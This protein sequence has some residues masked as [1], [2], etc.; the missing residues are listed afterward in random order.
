MTNKNKILILDQLKNDEIYRIKFSR[1]DLIGKLRYRSAKYCITPK[2]RFEKYVVLVG[3][4]IGRSWKL[5]ELHNRIDTKNVFYGY[6][7]KYNYDKTN[8]IEGLIKVQYKP[9]A[10]I[11]K[12]CSA[13]FPRNI[14][15]SMEQLVE[16]IYALRKNGIDPI[17]ATVVPVTEENNQKNSEKMKS[18]NRYNAV[19]RSYAK[20]NNIAVLDMQ[21]ILSDTNK[22][23]Y[24]SEKYSLSDGYHLKWE[25]YIKLLDKELVEFIQNNI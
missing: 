7:G 2:A 14:K 8:I 17:L 6:R 19:L 10:V 16:W 5:N 12:E 3:A 1:A 9:D 24:L 25:T 18:I 20:N 15:D 22:Q 4:S 11:I 13:Y 23:M 21:K